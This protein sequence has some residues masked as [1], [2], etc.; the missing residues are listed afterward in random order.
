MN[1][2]PL[3]FSVFSYVPWGRYI[4]Y[5]PVLGDFACFSGSTLSSD[6][7][8]FNS[9]FCKEIDDPQNSVSSNSYTA[10]GRNR[11]PESRPSPMRG[12]LAPSRNIL[13]TLFRRGH[14]KIAVSMRDRWA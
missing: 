9:L 4:R 6:A 7:T 8:V 3:L 1:P 11:P 10:F 14:H 12:F 13:V 2:P 5:C